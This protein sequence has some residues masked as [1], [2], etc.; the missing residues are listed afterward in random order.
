M[1]NY[2]DLGLV[3]KSSC[4]WICHPRFQ[5]Q[6][7]GADAGYRYGCRRDKVTRHHAGV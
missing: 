7:D 1:V 6:H 5:F 2:K 4:R 3:N